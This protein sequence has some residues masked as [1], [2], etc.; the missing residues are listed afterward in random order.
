MVKTFLDNR[1]V[2]ISR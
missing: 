1:K 2:K